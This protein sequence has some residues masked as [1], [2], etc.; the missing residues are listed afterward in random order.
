M[1]K[2]LRESIDLRLIEIINTL[3]R[4]EQRRLN[5]N[6]LA[7]IYMRHGE[8]D[9]VDDMLKNI[10]ADGLSRSEVKTK[11]P[12]LA[13]IGILYA[14]LGK[15]KI[16]KKL[17]T[18]SINTA[19]RVKKTSLYNHLLNRIF[20]S[21]VKEVI[22]DD[23]SPDVKK[24]CASCALRVKKH[25]KDCFAG[26]LYIPTLVSLYSY[27]NK[28]N[29][30]IEKR[31]DRAVKDL[32]KIRLSASI[33]PAECFFLAIEYLKLN[34]IRKAIKL[35][36]LQHPDTD[37]TTN[38]KYNLIYTDLI[39]ASIY[40]KKNAI[41]INILKKKL[42]GA[43]TMIKNAKNTDELTFNAQL[44]SEVG[45]KKDAAALLSAVMLQIKKTKNKNQTIC[46]RLNFLA[47]EFMKADCKEKALS[48]V[49]MAVKL[50]K[51]GT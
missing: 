29:N 51:T 31:L 41:A 16:A 36:L 10:L 35:L 1:K 3:R 21:F 24:I 13:G 34:N 14:K 25:I 4:P 9:K 11:V 15:M 6:I 17:L 49:K 42:G 7:Q 2:E 50:S 23:T 44:C 46:N 18:Q 45:L 48:V 43:G 33:A 19:L 28:P 38:E 47:D 5:S 12:E 27:F 39:E 22:K 37:L 32:L 30:E 20:Y 26:A 40:A 8:K